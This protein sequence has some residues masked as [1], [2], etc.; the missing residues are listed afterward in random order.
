M[1]NYWK[2]YVKYLQCLSSQLWSTWL[3]KTH[4]SKKENMSS[5]GVGR[6]FAGA[7]EDGC[8]AI[9]D[10]P[11][12]VLLVFTILLLSYVL[13]TSWL[14]ESLS[15]HAVPDRLSEF[16]S[17]LVRLFAILALS[18]HVIRFSLFGGDGSR[19][20]GFLDSQLWQAFR[21]IFGV[22]LLSI[23]G[24]TVLGLVVVFTM[25]NS[26]LW[27]MWTAAAIVLPIVCVSLFVG[28]RIS[29]ALCHVVTGNNAPLR[30]SWQST[31]GHVFAIG[32]TH[33]LAAM[34]LSFVLVLA[35]LAMR[36]VAHVTDAASMS[37]YFALLHVVAVMGGASISSASSAWAY[38]RIFT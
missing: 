13:P 22:A 36:P 7:W 5:I 12:S 29:L 26:G 25:H 32:W 19:S 27:G 1:R 6:C 31:R 30:S 35:Y 3:S 10:R 23:S 17:S 18:L 16:L 2:W 21:V 14:F 9:I 33:F 34:P 24:V 37:F 8:A 4:L 38:R 11:G 15:L 20:F 28:S